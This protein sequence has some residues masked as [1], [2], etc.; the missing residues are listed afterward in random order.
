MYILMRVSHP[1][2]PELRA[3]SHPHFLS[4]HSNDTVQRRRAG[5]PAREP[6]QEEPLADTRGE[7]KENTIST[8]HQTQP[9]YCGDAEGRRV[10]KRPSRVGA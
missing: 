6:T 3:H 10:A 7:D 8:M 5:E 4:I 9:R 2:T 1:H